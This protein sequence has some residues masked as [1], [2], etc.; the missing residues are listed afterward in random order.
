[1]AATT[2]TFVTLHFNFTSAGGIDKKLFHTASGGTDTTFDGETLDKLFR[3]MVIIN[4]SKN[5]DLRFSIEDRTI[6]MTAKGEGII[7]VPPGLSYD[8][9]HV[10]I[11]RLQLYLDGKGDVEVQLWPERNQ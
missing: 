10:F 2:F 9:P 8:L 7:T 5:N 1:M 11:V 6:T 4:H 3:A